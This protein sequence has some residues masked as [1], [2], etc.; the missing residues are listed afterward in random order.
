MKKIATLLVILF[1]AAAPIWAQKNTPQ[2]KS[3]VNKEYDENGNLIQY[4]STFVWQWNSDS[5]MN[6]SFDDNFAFGKEF[7][8]MFGEFFGDSIFEPFGFLN[9]HQFQTFNDEDFFRNFQ[10]SFPDS[11]FIQ[12][13]P[14]ES[15]SITGFDFGHQSPGHFDFPD[16]EELQKQMFE[17]FNHQNLVHP[18]FI[19]PGQQEE[20]DELIRKQQKEKE[21]FLKKWENQSPKKTY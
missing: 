9:D 11:A 17:K 3:I 13:F 4:D 7:P 21:E 8:G 18:K 5:T 2:E 12:G 1:C 16:L 6:F 15:D 10:H 14:F 20:W 19:S